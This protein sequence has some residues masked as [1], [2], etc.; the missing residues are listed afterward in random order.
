MPEDLGFEGGEG[1]I[2]GE[3]GGAAPSAEKLQKLDQLLEKTALYAQFL[4]ESVRDIDGKLAQAARTKADANST[5]DEPARS[6]RKPSEPSDQTKS[7]KK[8]KTSGSSSY[9][10]DSSA[11]PSDETNQK[12]QEPSDGTAAAVEQKPI[13]ETR[14]LLPLINGELRDYQ[15][16]GVRWLISLYHNGMNGVLADEMGLGKTVQTVGFLSFMFH[17]GI[18]GPFIVLAPLSTLPNWKSE[19]ERWCPS[20][21]A[22][23]YHGNKDE[24]SELQNEILRRK[25]DSNF[26]TILTSYEVFMRD[27]AALNKLNYKYLVVDEGHRLKNFDCKLI[28]QVRQINT[29]NKL[30]LTGTP[31]QNRLTELW[32]LLNFLAPEVFANMGEFQSWFAF[33]DYIGSENEKVIEAQRNESLVSKLHQI[34]SPYLLRREKKDVESALPK[35]KEVVLYAQLAE[36][37]RTLTQAYLDGSIESVL[38]K[39]S[40]DGN[41]A[42]IRGLNNELM[43]LR[44][45]CNHP[46][47]LTGQFDTSGEFPSPE[48]LMKQCG[49]LQLLERVLERLRCNQHKVLIFSQMSQMLD[50]LEHV[51]DQRGWG[52]CRIDGTVAMEDRQEQIRKFNEDPNTFVFLLTTR[53][54]GLGLNLMAADTVRVH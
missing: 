8:R 4:D 14:A 48:K 22:I 3:N 40:E 17:R 23:L 52:C 54:G 32:S 37:Q 11:P 25:V 18:H 29:D 43:Q 12:E 19:F 28:K 49:K 38:K 30:L 10:D 5:G 9:A 36:E 34:I 16:R 6:K 50:L 35:K 7:P 20:M 26:P 21:S 15:L 24:R 46:D 13:S 41:K 44:K 42:A 53:A 1:G 39:R 47:L 45:V 2:N 31:L 27:R 51:L 33:G